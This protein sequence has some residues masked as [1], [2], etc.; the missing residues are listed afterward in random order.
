MIIKMMTS[1]PASGP[2]PACVD[3]VVDQVAEHRCLR[4]AEQVV[5]VVVTEHRQGHDHE[6][7]Q[8][9]GPRQRQRHAPERLVR[10]STQIAARLQ[11]ALVDAVQRAEQRQDHERDVAV[12][13]PEDHG[14]VLARE[15]V[16]RFADDVQAG[17]DVV[18]VAVRLQQALP[19]VD[20]H[21]VADPER[22]DQQDQH[23]HPVLARVSSRVVGHR[24]AHHQADEA[25]REHVGERADQRSLVDGLARVEL[26]E[27]F[28]EGGE[29]PPPRLI[30]RERLAEDRVDRAERHG[31]HREE[32]QQ[33][34]QRQ[35]D[36]PR[37]RERGPVPPR[38]PSPAGFAR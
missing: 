10:A 26:A 12:D 17:Q 15:P 5:R 32:R 8:D 7:R 3:G 23:Q 19:G 6:P 16:H 13:Q 2:R 36:D 4:R 21:Q 34:Q 11:Q 38:V 31:Q 1:E 24:V 29:A 28:V 27:R 22:R 20:P 18:H 33:E 37:H 14:D 35:P 25:R 30:H 9:R